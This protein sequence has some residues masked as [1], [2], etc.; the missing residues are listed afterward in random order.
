MSP[1]Q[2]NPQNTAATEAT[3]RAVTRR[4]P[5]TMTRVLRGPSLGGQS[6]M[7]MSNE[8]YEYPCSSSEPHGRDILG[9]V[10]LGEWISDLM[11]TM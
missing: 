9:G 4:L 11:R 7:R 5:R 1:N 8:R 10:R 2:R 3:T 6:H